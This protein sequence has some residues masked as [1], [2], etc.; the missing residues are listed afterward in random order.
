M[1][2]FYL[3]MVE[4]PEEKSLVEYLY[5]NYRQIMYKT[6]FSILHNSND[7][8]DA[9]HEAFLRVV[10]NISKFSEYSSNENLSYLVITVRGISLDMLAA[11]KRKTVLD[12]EMPDTID[13]EE[14]AEQKANYE[15]AIKNIGN[16]TPALRNIATLYFVKQMNYAEISQLLDKNIST[17]RSSISRAKS[18]LRTPEKENSNE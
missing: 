6:A 7:A 18:I 15:T 16:L 1:L 8:E 12:E 3:Q 10:K 14:I 5:N 17:I 9:V 4:T 11:Q 2:S 13:V